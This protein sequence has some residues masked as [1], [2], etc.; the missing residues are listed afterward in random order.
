MLQILLLDEA[1]SALDTKSER[2]VQAAID[3]L[4]AGAGA[5]GGAGSRTSI[6]IAHRLS[7]VRSA[8]RIVW[9]EAGR[10]VEC[11]SHDEL[12][13]LP[14]GRYRAAIDKQS[15]G[16]AVS[17]AV[18]RAGSASGFASA[19]AI[20]EASEDVEADG[21]DD[22]EEGGVGAV[23]PPTGSVASAAAPSSA[24]SPA[25]PP[26]AGEHAAVAVGASAE[27]VAV[28]V[29]PAHGDSPAKPAS[30]GEAHAAH[31]GHESGA[32]MAESMGHAVMA[33]AE[34]IAGSFGSGS[35]EMEQSGAAMP[36]PVPVRRPSSV[37]SPATAAAADA[38]IAHSASSARRPRGTSAAGSSASVAP[39]AAATGADD[40]PAGASTGAEDPD[41]EPV[42]PPVKSSRVWAFQKPEMPHL[43]L[44]VLS[45]AV[46]GASMPAFSI[47]F[48]R[49]TAV[50]YNPDSAVIR[51]E[52]PRYMGWFFFIGIL[53]FFG[54]LGMWSLFSIAGERLT[55]RLRV[56]TYRAVM[57]Q[58]IVRSLLRCCRC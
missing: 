31:H 17:G 42:Y 20:D 49:M 51:E 25:A 43:V 56:A 33:A 28:A 54:Q 21:E 38:A 10:I 41:K 46:A 15:L 47:I 26:A 23:S 55:R 11:G 37:A 7:T 48:A 1:T 34:T 16:R 13:A 39:A 18:R 12:M 36:F 40:K 50:F 22:G 32:H 29:T 5:D 24:A 6:V 14:G 58:E 52:T 9:L 8:S 45:A 57:R 19:T 53:A 2:V 35:A 44:A 4:L 3:R 27:Q 30:D